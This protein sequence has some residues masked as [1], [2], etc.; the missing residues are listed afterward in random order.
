MGHECSD[1]IDLVGA[2]L[3]VGAEYKIARTGNR[4]D[5]K[6]TTHQRLQL[7]D[8]TTAILGENRRACLA[9]CVQDVYEHASTKRG[10]DGV[11]TFRT[12]PLDLQEGLT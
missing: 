12:K 3:G 8:A 1:L 11:C 9:G 10:E 2:A 6:I 5:L 7:I 4:N